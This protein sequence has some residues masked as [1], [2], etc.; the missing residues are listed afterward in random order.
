LSFAALEGG[1]VREHARHAPLFETLEPRREH[2]GMYDELFEAF[3]GYY[4]NN[5]RWLARLNAA[6]EARAQAA[7][8]G[9]SRAEGDDHAGA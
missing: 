3:L 5:R 2:R 4:K 8:R 6:P 1:T 7:S 9:P